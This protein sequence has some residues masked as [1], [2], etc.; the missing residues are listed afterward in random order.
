MPPWDRR[1]WVRKIL[2]LTQ[3]FDGKLS[4]HFRADSILMF[5][6]SRP[7]LRSKMLRDEKTFGSLRLRNL[8]N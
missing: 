4:V 7:F 5:A 2:N 8:S 6:A 3:T 1:T